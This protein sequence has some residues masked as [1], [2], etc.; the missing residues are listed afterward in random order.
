M[1][2]FLCSLSTSVLADIVTSGNCEEHHQMNS[3]DDG[4]PPVP[5]VD[6]ECCKSALCPSCPAGIALLNSGLEL[7]PSVS[8]LLAGEERSSTKLEYFPPFRPPRA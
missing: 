4:A 5:G 6:S 3:G 7:E 2:L 8:A 1:L